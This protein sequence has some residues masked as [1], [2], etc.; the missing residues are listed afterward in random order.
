VDWKFA[1]RGWLGTFGNETK[2]NPAKSHPAPAL[3]FTGLIELPHYSVRVLSP[4]KNKNSQP[5]NVSWLDKT[6]DHFSVEIE[7]LSADKLTI[8]IFDWHPTRKPK[9]HKPLGYE[10]GFWLR[11]V[12]NQLEEIVM[13]NR[14]K[15]KYTR[16][17]SI[18]HLQFSAP[19]E[20]YV[21][22]DSQ[23]WSIY[24]DKYI[25]EPIQ[26]VEFSINEQNRFKQLLING[27]ESN[28]KLSNEN[29]KKGFYLKPGSFYQFQL[30]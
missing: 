11:Y 9:T 20:G 17:K 13:M 27:K 2:I 22:K 21:T 29:E 28:L 7:H 3:L 24:I 25:D 4:S 18:V 16:N 8:D 6:D 19:V 1:G 10:N 30:N 15:I 5:I 23:G 26:I 12:E 14:K